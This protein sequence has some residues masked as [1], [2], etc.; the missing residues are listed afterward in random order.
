MATP[1]KT[2]IVS[3]QNPVKIAAAR[4]GFTRMFPDIPFTFRGMSVPSG[5]ADQPITDAETLQGALNRAHNVREL[6]PT[7]DYWIGIEGGVD[8]EQKTQLG[9]ASKRPGA[10]LQSF[11][12]VVVVGREGRQKGAV[13][14][15]TG[16]EADSSGREEWRTGKARTSAF[17]QPEEVA[18]LVR[19]G[20]ELGHAD[21][22]VFGKTNSKH[23]SGSVG[24][25]T[26][27]LI[28]RSAY[29][30]QAVILALIPFKNSTLTF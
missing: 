24:L 16:S 6:E 5:V 10:S 20:M 28:D 3:S 7:A 18:T 15:T 13:T 17:Y 2:V 26:G 14:T 8:D 30:M 23:H 27:D 25:L 4:D 1:E 12:W 9:G 21:D 29:Y 11:A 19:G 22:E